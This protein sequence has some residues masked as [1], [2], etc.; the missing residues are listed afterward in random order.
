MID[1]SDVMT[2]TVDRRDPAIVYA[3]ACSGIYR[4]GD[5]AAR[6]MRIRGIPSTD[7]A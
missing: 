5:G 1:D 4:S 2:M 6:W 7:P 3:T